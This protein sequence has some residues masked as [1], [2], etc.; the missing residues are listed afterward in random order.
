MKYL[1]ALLPII[2]PLA[3]ATR[4]AYCL[5]VSLGWD[6]LLSAYSGGMPGETLSGRA[7]TA[8]REGKLRGRI[9]APMINFVMRSPTHCQRA[10]EDDIARARAVIKDDTRA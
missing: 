8:Q 5:N 3:L 7:G 6:V 10:I 2:I 1:L 9:F 4:S